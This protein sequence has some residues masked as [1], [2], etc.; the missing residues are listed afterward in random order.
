VNPPTKLAG[1]EAPNCT[2]DARGEA[3][4][5]NAMTGLGIWPYSKRVLTKEAVPSE[6]GPNP[7]VPSIPFF[8]PDWLV[9]PKNWKSV[10]QL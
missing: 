2:V 6:S 8:K 4:S 1:S 5:W 3:L 9:I 7:K 10:T